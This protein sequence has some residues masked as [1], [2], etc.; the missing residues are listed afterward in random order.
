MIESGKDNTALV[1]GVQNYFIVY[2]TPQIHLI[3]TQIDI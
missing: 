3:E 2:S 1:P